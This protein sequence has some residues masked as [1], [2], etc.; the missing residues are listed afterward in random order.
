MKRIVLD[1]CILLSIFLLPW[2]ITLFLSAVGMFLYENFYE[3]I[4]AFLFV[5]AVYGFGSTGV[6]G[7]KVYLPLILFVIFIAFSFVKKQFIF[8]QKQ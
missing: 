3:F 4:I 7:S 8:Y 2:W 5:Y 6:L 1:I